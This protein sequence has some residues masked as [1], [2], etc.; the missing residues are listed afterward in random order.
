MPPETPWNQSAFQG[1]FHELLAVVALKFLISRLSV[2]ISHPLLVGQLFLRGR[3]PGFHPLLR[4]DG[5]LRPVPSLLLRKCNGR[6]REHKTQHGDQLF[7]DGLISRLLNMMPGGPDDGLT[8]GRG[9]RLTQIE[10]AGQKFV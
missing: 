3:L 6:C 1:D 9:S 8:H 10:R 5:V 2:A 4:R 7:H